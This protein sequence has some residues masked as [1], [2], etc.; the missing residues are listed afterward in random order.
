MIIN[1]QILNFSF[2]FFILSSRNSFLK[3]TLMTYDLMAEGGGWLQRS[4]VP[5]IKRKVSPNKTNPTRR[6][7]Q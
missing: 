1:V 7:V 6:R 5:T 4:I 2:V 3:I